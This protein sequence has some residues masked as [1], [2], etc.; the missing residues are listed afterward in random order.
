MNALDLALNGMSDEK[1][2]LAEK[3]SIV[4]QLVT[5]GATMTRNSKAWQ[6]GKTPFHWRR[7]P[8]SGAGSS[9][10]GGGGGPRA[11]AASEQVGRLAAR[12]TGRIADDD[13][14]LTG[15]TMVAVVGDEDSD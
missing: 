11:S 9:G 15:D 8:V 12:R 13:P 4:S 5:A 3:S 1:K 10:D 7:V 14:M 2:A 6:T